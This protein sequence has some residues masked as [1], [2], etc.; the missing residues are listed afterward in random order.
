MAPT[1]YITRGVSGSG[2]STWA[3]SRKGAVVVSRD[4]LRKAAFGTDGP[5]YYEV[6]RDVLRKREDYITSVENP[7]I[8]AALAAGMDVVSDNTHTMMKYVNRVAKIGYACGANVELK[9]FD[10]PLDEAIRRVT[11]RA[12]S[13][14]RD[15]PVDAIKRQHQQLAGNKNA[16]LTP[17]PPIVPYNGTPGKPEAILVDIDGTLAHMRDLRGPFDWAKVGVDEP[18]LN[19]IRVIN[20]I[21]TGMAFESESSGNPMDDAKI[22]VM[23]GR[24]AVCRPE[25][26]RWLNAN[27]VYYD[28]LFMRPEGD[29][30]ADNIVKHELFNQ[31]IRDNYDVVM[32]FDDRNQVVDM[33]RAMGVQVAQVAVGDF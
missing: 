9:V 30:R 31:H 4:D 32:V 17:P 10:V 25:T 15:V 33:W 12:G 11:D 29:M 2:K 13:G 26:E 24:D 22:I 28:H 20:W 27:N 1:L 5:D 3:R 14:G 18:D 8:W 6:S 19:V 21:N 23:S 16:T 7:M